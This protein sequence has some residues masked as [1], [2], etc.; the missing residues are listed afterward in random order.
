[1]LEFFKLPLR[2]DAGRLAADLDRVPVHEWKPHYNSE[3]YVG[4]WSGAALRSAGGVAGKIYPDPGATQ[5][6][7][8]TALLECCPYFR[9]VLAQFQCP[10]KAVRLLRLAPGA[11][12]REHRD[13]NLGLEDGEARLHVP[14]T[15]NPDVLFFVNGHS[16]RMGVGET[17]YVNFG[18][19]HRVANRGQSDRVHLVIDCIANDWLRSHLPSIPPLEPLEHPNLPRAAENLARFALLVFEDAAL[20]EELG[21]IIDRG[22]FLEWVVRTGEARGFGFTAEHVQQAMQEGRRTWLERR[23][24]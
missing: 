22:L 20:Q 4:A 12:V 23:I 9:E 19:P 5:P 21:E 2:F 3:D 13:P 6:F 17:W 7:A 16:L 18:L 11:R 10:L 1:M 14:I 8:D 15:T 24:Q